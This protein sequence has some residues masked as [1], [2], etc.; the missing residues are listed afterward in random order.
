MRRHLL[1]LVPLLLVVGCAPGN[2]ET[3]RIAS[4]VAVAIAHPRQETAEGFHR[5]AVS[6][7]A[8]QDGRL[9]VLVAE[10]L[11]APQL[12]DPVVRMVWRVHLPES[13]YGFS[14]SEPVTACYELE[15]SRYGAVEEPSRVTCPSGAEPLVPSPVTREPQRVVPDGAEVVLAR[16][17]PG[18]GERVDL[19][20]VRWSVLDSLADPP[21]DPESGLTDRPPALSVAVRGGDVGVALEGDDRDRLLA[22][23]VD[24][25]SEVWR[26]D[27]AQL[28]P[29]E[30]SCDADTALSGGGRAP[31]S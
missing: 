29:G 28:A 23:W 15:L 4:T 5:A 22:A 7:A 19:E 6:T 26:P 12:V 1:A 8:G 16:A 9:A 14:V 11:E 3:D 20:R 18:P 25:R 13:G 2:A 21:V 30:L 24:G 31:N 10:P 17:L 27:R